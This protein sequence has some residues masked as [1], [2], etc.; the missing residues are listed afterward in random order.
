MKMLQEVR[1]EILA[2]IGFSDTQGHD[3]NKL[4]IDTM[5]EHAQNRLYFHYDYMQTRKTSNKTLAAGSVLYDVPTD[6]DYRRI[7]DMLIINDN[8]KYQP[9]K[10]GVDYQDE[11]ITDRSIPTKY[12]F[13]NGQILVS[14]TPDNA[15]VVRF[16]YFQ[17]PSVLTQD[18]DVLTIDDEIVFTLAL[19]DAKNHYR[20]ESAIEQAE[21]KA[22]LNKKQAATFG[23]KRFFR[24]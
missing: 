6:C 1:K 22:Q 9:L 4:L 10:H 21:F 2:R 23:D 8:G 15:Y 24:V 19:V 20:M 18:S 7:I 17:K 16:E 11:N 13:R 3:N 5:I 14:P 12:D